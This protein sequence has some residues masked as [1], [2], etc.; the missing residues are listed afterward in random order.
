MALS[1]DH[2]LKGFSDTKFAV[3]RNDFEFLQSIICNFVYY[4][5]YNTNYTFN[6]SLYCSL[7]FLKQQENMKSIQ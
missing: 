5:V 7:I 4:Y 1:L 6:F 3:E 2:K